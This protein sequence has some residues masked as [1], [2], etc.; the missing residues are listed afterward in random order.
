MPE[1]GGKAK[2][3]EGQAAEFRRQYGHVA[4]RQVDE[5]QDEQGNFN[6]KDAGEEETLPGQQ[7]V[8][9]GSVEHQQALNSYPTATHYGPDVNVVAGPQSENEGEGGGAQEAPKQVDVPH[10][11]QDGDKLTCTMGNWEGEPTSYSYQ[12]KQD[13]ENAG[14]ASDVGE[15]DVTEADVGTMMSCVVTASN[16]A[17]ETEADPSNEVEVTSPLGRR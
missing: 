3:R 14:E 8:V 17:G 9:A 13:G 7:E 10:V 6:F 2:D 11:Q 5:Q 15:Y 16:D 1:T 12:W 4:Q